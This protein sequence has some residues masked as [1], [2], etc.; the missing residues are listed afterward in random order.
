MSYENTNVSEFGID[1][2]EVGNEEEFNRWFIGR[3]ME[4]RSLDELAEWI[5]ED[6]VDKIIGIT[7]W[8]EGIAY[9][10][11][12]R[13]ICYW[14]LLHLLFVYSGN[15]ETIANIYNDEVFHFLDNVRI[16]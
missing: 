13:T 5:N 8:D 7:E 16:V 4:S 2:D 1:F 9:S 11:N 3:M 6:V 15:G 10:V 12:S 14:Y